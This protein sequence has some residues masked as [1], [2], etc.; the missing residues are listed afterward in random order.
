M[1]LNNCDKQMLFLLTYRLSSLLPSHSLLTTTTLAFCSLILVTTTF[2]FCSLVL[3][4]ATF[5]LCVFSLTISTLAFCSLSLAAPALAFL[6]KALHTLH[7]GLTF[8]LVDHAII[9]LVDLVK[10][11]FMS[12]HE[13]FPGDNSI[14]IGIHAGHT[15]LAFLAL[16]ATAFTF[17]QQHVAGGKRLHAKRVLIY[18]SSVVEVSTADFGFQAV[19]VPAAVWLFGSGLLGLMGV[20]RRNR[21]S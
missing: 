6:H 7:V 3:A 12:L 15:A 17:C 5:S 14:T 18:P 4:T 11:G 19:P 1:A 8:G 21:R 9:I 2:A 10:H 13:F 20:V 16:A